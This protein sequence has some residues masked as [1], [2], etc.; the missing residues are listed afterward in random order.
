MAYYHS[1][2]GTKRRSRRAVTFRAI[3]P[4][5]EILDEKRADKIVADILARQKVT[6]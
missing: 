2:Q 6:S 3:K 1:L 4:L 5:P